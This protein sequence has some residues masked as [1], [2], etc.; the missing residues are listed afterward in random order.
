MNRILLILGLF[1]SLALL[2][3]CS[4]SE[5]KTG[6]E[7]EIALEENI[8]YNQDNSATSLDWNGTYEGI[9]PCASC[10]GIET[11]LTLNTDLT[12]KLVTNY[13]GRNDALEQENTGSF[14]W[15][16]TGSIITLAKVAQ[17]PRQYKV[18]E[19]RIWQLDMKGK[20]IKGDLADHYILTKK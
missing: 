17:G 9:V 3:S 6:L 5:Q 16:K 18:G 11:R 13:L 8:L 1:T 4:N 15:D 20:I 12:Y 10:E 19:N 2:A 14:T 7:E